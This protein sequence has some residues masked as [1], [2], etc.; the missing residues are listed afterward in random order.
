MIKSFRGKLADGAQETIRLSTKDGLTGYKIH[1]F[2]ILPSEPGESSVESTVKI[3]TVDPGFSAATPA[4]NTVDMTDP[5]LIAAAFYQ[6]GATIDNTQ[7]RTLIVDT[8]VFNQDIFV[9]HSDVGGNVDMNY[10]IELEV[11]KLD[12][13]EAT[14]ATLK[15]MRGRE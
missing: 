8:M 5:T 1:K 13:N 12:L 2:Q 6:D 7:N 11:M 4:T 3:Y 9:T 14:V 15:D 10:L